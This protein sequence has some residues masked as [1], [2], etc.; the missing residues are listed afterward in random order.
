MPSKER[1]TMHGPGG[2]GGGGGG[3]QQA[4]FNI[5]PRYFFSLFLLKDCRK[6]I[7]NACYLRVVAWL[8]FFVHKKNFTNLKKM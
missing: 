2:G 5:F 4:T 7:S 8:L 3:G 6:E 1:K